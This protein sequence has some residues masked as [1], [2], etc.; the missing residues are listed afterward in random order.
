MNDIATL[1][2]EVDRFIH[3]NSSEF[4]SFRRQLHAQPELSHQ[5]FQTTEVLAERLEQL[6]FEV[7]VREEETGLVADFIPHDF[8]PEADP[9]VAVRSDIDAL[10]IDEQ[11]DTPYTSEKEGIMHACGHDVHMAMVTGTGASLRELR[12][13]LPGRLRLIF[14]HA[15]EVVP[16]GASDMISFGAMDGVDA[17]IG[18]HCDPELEVG[19]IGLKEGPFTAAF[20]KFH[21]K[22][23]GKGGHGARPHHCVDPI[24]VATNLASSLYQI[25]DRHFDA[26]DPII[27]SIGSITA[28]DTPNVIPDEAEIKGTVRTLSQEHRDEVDSLLNKIAGGVCM[29][30]GASYDLDLVRGAPAVVNDP[31]VIGTLQAAAR[32]IPE[33]EEPIHE[34]PKAS[35][36]GEDFSYYLQRAPGAMFRLG[37]ASPSPHPKHMLHSSR[38]DVD[39]RSIGIGIRILSRA[40]L[41][42]MRDLKERER[43]DSNLGLETVEQQ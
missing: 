18:L 42:L 7:S 27:I 11:N 38:F 41:K 14:Q 26:R 4:V 28:G 21:F 15:E 2:D 19:N 17:V 30:H 25:P 37:T 29:T 3:A 33:L 23:V 20:D 13:E 36:G 9:T 31:D 5:E 24:L 16:G 12:E 40:C 22:I 35:M 43:L 32:D 8:D 39:E 34:I 6:G 10:P 1:S